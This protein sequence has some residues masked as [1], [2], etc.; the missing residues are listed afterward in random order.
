[1]KDDL[2]TAE[3][4][5]TAMLRVSMTI[6]G[7]GRGGGRDRVAALPSST[8]RRSRIVSRVVRRV[9]GGGPGAGPC[10]GLILGVRGRG[11]GATF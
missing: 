4:P 2:P 8:A 10:E 1:M 3:L 6:T 5:M 9:A 11:G 7:A